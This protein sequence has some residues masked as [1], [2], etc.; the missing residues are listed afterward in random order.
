ME[1]VSGATGFPCR[2]SS[3]S[4]QFFLNGVRQSM[5]FPFEMAAVIYGIERSV[6][7]IIGTPDIYSGNGMRLPLLLS[8]IGLW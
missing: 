4:I 2:P 7:S 5:S 3:P 1:G 8:L 6:R